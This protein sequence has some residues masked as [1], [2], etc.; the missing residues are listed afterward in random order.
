MNHNRKLRMSSEYR[1]SSILT[2]ALAFLHSV[3]AIT[4]TMPACLRRRWAPSPLLLPP[5]PLVPPLEVQGVSAA[6]LAFPEDEDWS[7]LCVDG[8][9]ARRSA[10]DVLD[11]DA[12]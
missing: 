11:S 10:M 9:M 6:P 2:F 7:V 8:A 4:V 3:H 12:S 1:Q 5:A